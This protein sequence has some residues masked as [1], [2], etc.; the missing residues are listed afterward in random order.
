MFARLALLKGFVKDRWDLICLLLE[1]GQSHCM[2]LTSLDYGS[3]VEVSRRSKAVNL[4][5]L[6][7]G[8]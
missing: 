2:K 7:A 6:L 4:N 8:A 1:S 5:A 3:W